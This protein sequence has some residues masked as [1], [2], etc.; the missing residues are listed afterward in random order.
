MGWYEQKL[1][2]RYWIEWREERENQKKKTK[3]SYERQHVYMCIYVH[4]FIHDKW[5]LTEKNAWNSLMSDITSAAIWCSCTCHSPDESM[6]LSQYWFSTRLLPSN[7]SHLK[8]E[9]VLHLNVEAIKYKALDTHFCSSSSQCV[10]V[11]V[12]LFGEPMPT[13]YRICKI[14]VRRYNLC[15]KKKEKQNEI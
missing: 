3:K 1:Y 2:D 14:C 7:W 13:H 9:Y 10:C 15:E 5:T 12:S 6:L 8:I 11:C 4:P